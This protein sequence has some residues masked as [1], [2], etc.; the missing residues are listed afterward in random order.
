MTPLRVLPRYPLDY[1]VSV[2]LLATNW[3]RAPLRETMRPRAEAD[4]G[5]QRGSR[6]RGA[7]KDAERL[8]G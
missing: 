6:Q 4:R 2:I 3:R 1:S 8:K 7:V 5:S